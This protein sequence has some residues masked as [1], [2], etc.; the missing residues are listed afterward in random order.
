M[1]KKIVLI[2]T[3]ICLFLATAYITIGKTGPDMLKEKRGQ[4]VAVMSKHYTAED[5]FDAGKETVI[6]LIKTPTAVTNYI[7]SGQELQ[8]Y[9][10]P[11]DPAA[12]GDVTSVY[13]V[14]SGQIIETGENNALGKYIKIRHEKAISV[15]GK[16]CRIYVKEG[17]HVR[18]GQVIGSYLQNEK[19]KFY[20]ELIEE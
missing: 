12:E 11:V 6:G 8:K 3:C 4:I 19:N 1:L 18:R 13:A 15:Y 5:I 9:A 14:A 16:C 10:E 7:I 17:E 20:Y 2:Q